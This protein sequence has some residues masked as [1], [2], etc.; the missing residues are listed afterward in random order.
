MQLKYFQDVTS[1]SELSK[2]YRKLAKKMHPDTAKTEEELIEKQKQF[3]EM[4]D[5]WSKK[6]WTAFSVLYDC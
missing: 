4:S 3:S 6:Y 5:E 2:Q 1:E